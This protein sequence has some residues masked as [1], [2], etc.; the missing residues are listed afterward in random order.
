MLIKNNRDYGFTLIE[1]IITLIILSII[2]SFSA[3]NF[4]QIIKSK[5]IEAIAINIVNLFNYSKIFSLNI[6][7]NIFICHGYIRI[8]SKLN[9]CINNTTTNTIPNA[10]IAY[11]SENNIGRYNSKND[12]K[13]IK[14][15]DN[16]N[17]EFKFY[18]LKSEEINNPILLDNPQFILL[19]NNKLAIN[20]KNKGDEISHIGNV[21][22]IIINDKHNKKICK[23]IKIESNGRAKVCDKKDIKDFNSSNFEICNCKN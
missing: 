18:T 20:E 9:N 2:L 8:N 1:M 17:I 16:K 23:V 5:K 14:I 21:A 12:I 10:F 13:V 19:T 22:K 4:I 6:N 3:P 7:E 11:K 15:D